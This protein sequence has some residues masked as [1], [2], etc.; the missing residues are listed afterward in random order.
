MVMLICLD[1]LKF[2]GQFLCQKSPSV[3]KE[4]KG[5]WPGVTNVK[6]FAMQYTVYGIHYNA[7][8]QPLSEI[9]PMQYTVYSTLPCYDQLFGKQF[10]PCHDPFN[11][12]LTFV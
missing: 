8:S 1:N 9:S 5:S 12:H 3:L 11:F 10:T 2:F 7:M 6:I 4:V